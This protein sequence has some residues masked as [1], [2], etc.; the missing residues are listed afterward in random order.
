MIATLAGVRR[1]YC[2]PIEDNDQSQGWVLSCLV[3]LAAALSAIA[4]QP[5]MAQSKGQNAL[6][7]GAMF[8]SQVERCWK[9]PALVSHEEAN[10]KVVLEINLTREGKL[11]GQPLVS[12]ES[13]PTASA[14]SKAYQENALR[15]IV[16]CQPY[17]LP[18]EDY[19]QWKHFMP[20]F[21]GRPVHPD[22]KG[23]RPAG[24]FDTRTPSICR[25]C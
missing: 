19:D 12:S 13:S 1:T 23:K 22:D 20:V 17:S 9:K 18:A 15:A 3:V 6:T 7:W 21:I 10:M 25:G 16:Q 14:F 11:V 24:L 8:T 2:M 5:A 4:I